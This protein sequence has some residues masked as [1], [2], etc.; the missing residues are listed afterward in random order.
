MQA[1]RRGRGQDAPWPPTGPPPATRP[2]RSRAPAP[3]SAARSRRRR[4]S[5]RG[6]RGRS[7]SRRPSGRRAP[8]ASPAMSASGRPPPRRCHTSPLVGGPEKPVAGRGE[9]Q[10]PFPGR[11]AEGVDLG[12]GQG[13]RDLLPGGARVAAPEGAERR[14]REDEARVGRRCGQRQD[15]AGRGPGLALPASR[16]RRRSAAGPPSVA[17][18]RRPPGSAATSAAWGW[19]S[20]PSTTVGRRRHGP[21]WETDR[22]TPSSVPARISSPSSASA[23]PRAP[24]GPRPTRV[25]GPSG[26][27]AC[28]HAAVLPVAHHADHDPPGVPVDEHAGEDLLGEAVVGGGPGRG[29]RRC[30]GA[31]RRRRCR[32]GCAAAPRDGAIALTT[33]SFRVASRQVDGSSLAHE[34][35]LRWCRRRRSSDRRDP[36]RRS[37]CA[38]CSTGCPWTFDQRA[39]RVRER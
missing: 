2:A 27:G 23:G 31:R 13:P 26:R 35:R 1:P 36:G 28:K 10:P 8:K 18:R 19:A 15:G 20:R 30:C 5:R 25:Q 29:R 11:N 17:A 21:Q 24:R 32:A 9:D 12:I 6:R 34:E 16:R 33:S 7:R 22:N 14:R 37:A 4:R 39:A 3:G 38:G